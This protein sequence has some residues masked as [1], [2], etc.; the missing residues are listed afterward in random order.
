VG[1]GAAI[2]VCL[3]AEIKFSRI[4]LGAMVIDSFNRSRFAEVYALLI[5]IVALAIAGNA[6]VNR[7]GQRRRSAPPEPALGMVQHG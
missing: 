1:L 6:L 7:L 3:I 5:V 2:A 4:G